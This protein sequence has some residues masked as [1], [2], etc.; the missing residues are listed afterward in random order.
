MTDGQITASSIGA[1]GVCE[2]N[3]DV[4][5][6]GGGESDI[7]GDIIMGDGA[8]KTV[9]GGKKW[10]ADR[11]QG[12][13][14]DRQ[15]AR[16][17][18]QLRHRAGRGD[19]TRLRTKHRARRLQD[20]RRREDVE[21][22]R[23]SATTRPARSSSSSTRRTRTSSTP[24]SGNRS[25][26]PWAMSSGGPG[27]GLYKSTDGGES[28]TEIT[29]NPGLPSGLWGKVGISVSGADSNRVYAL[30]EN[31]P[32][33]GLFVSDDAGAT[34]KLMSDNR[35]IRQRA[36]YYTR[37]YA[38]PKVKDTVWILNVNIYKS[39]DAGKTLTNVRVPH[40]DNH[41]L[42]IAPSDSNRMIEANDGGANVSVNGGQTWTDQDF[43][44]AQFYHVFLTVARP[45]SDLWRAAG[46][47]DGLHVE[48]I[49]RAG[50][51]RVL[52]RRRRRRERLH[53]ARSARP[54]RLLRRQLRRLPDALRPP[55]RPAAQHQHLARQPDG[56]RLGR[57]HRALP[58]DVPDRVLAD[59]QEDDLRL[60]PAPVEDDQRRPELAA[61][62]P[63]SVAPR[64]EDHGRLGRADHQGQ[65]RRGNLRR[66]V[67]DCAVVPGRQHDL[68]GVG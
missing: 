11:T 44:T 54:G 22:A 29:R 6:I 25:A 14:G 58:V 8:Y 43:P 36:F 48:P 64:S 33:G 57:D 10:E 47:L 13:A 49:R 20:H 18:G 60:V 41:D 39:T 63:R 4:V 40:G 9:D 59:R 23:S 55:H 38:D 46:Q 12:L 15:A 28:W 32:G 26:I 53:R 16:A 66:A 27:S 51:R 65:H 17:P 61:D 31:D 50:R 30:I 19:G 45:V 62:E 2:A 3:P 67:H 56:L 5:Y 68:G 24:R 34:W 52:L 1:I 42:W 35:N 21:S 37:V 7:R